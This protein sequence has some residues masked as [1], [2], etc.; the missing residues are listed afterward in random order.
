MAKRGRVIPLPMKA[1]PRQAISD[2]V[3]NRLHDECQVRGKAAEIARTTG[4]STAHIT[5]IQK[6]ERGVGDDAARALGTYWGL[7]FAQLEEEAVRWN[8]AHADRESAPV[9]I[10]GRRGTWG[11]HPRWEAELAQAKSMRASVMPHVPERFLVSLAGAVVPDREPTAG[12]ILRLAE[13]LFVTEGTDTSGEERK[14]LAERS[15]GSR[16]EPGPR[17]D[18]D[19][20]DRDGGADGSKPQVAKTKHQGRR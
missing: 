8:A 5:N 3:R 17:S 6:S 1:G 20:S 12:L 11:E 14:A 15:P 16:S 2:Y 13:S 19:K 18:L 10:S 7:S 4:L 9:S